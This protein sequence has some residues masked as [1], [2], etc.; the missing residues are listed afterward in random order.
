MKRK[1]LGAS[2]VAGAQ[3]RFPSALVTLTSRKAITGMNSN[4]SLLPKLVT[5]TAT[6]G[7][8]PERKRRAE[9]TETQ[10]TSPSQGPGGQAALPHMKHL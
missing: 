5:L 4:K 3:W 1:A 9:P 2:S 8:L 6:P 10:G 7:S